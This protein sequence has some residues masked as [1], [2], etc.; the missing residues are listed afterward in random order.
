MKIGFLVLSVLIGSTLL[1]AQD[2]PDP[3]C[4][5]A[6]DDRCDG[7]TSCA[8]TTFTHIGDTP[9]FAC[10]TIC[11]G[12]GDHSHCRMTATVTPVGGTTPVATCQNWNGSDCWEVSSPN[13]V[14]LSLQNNVQYQLKVCLENCGTNCCGHCRAVTM[15]K[16]KYATCPAP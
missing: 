5:A 4:Y 13:W 3:Y 9:S 16:Q 12:S 10:W 8:T 7:S 11:D 1:L 6:V 14:E 15:V 2:A